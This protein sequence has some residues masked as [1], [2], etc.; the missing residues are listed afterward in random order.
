MREGIWLWSRACVTEV[1][2]EFSFGS[3]GQR[4][5]TRTHTAQEF[6]LSPRAITLRRRGEG[7]LA[8]PKRR[9]LGAHWQA[10]VSQAVVA[11]YPRPHSRAPAGGVD[12]RHL[13][14]IHR[15]PIP[16]S[17]SAASR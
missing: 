7:L 13:S 12:R 5:P 6:R 10:G 9:G 11:G 1:R 2:P 17:V 4:A 14:E 15:S 8:C 16:R 3:R